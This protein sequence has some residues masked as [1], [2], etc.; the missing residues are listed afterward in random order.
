MSDDY[1]LSHSRLVTRDLDEARSYIAGAWERHTSELRHGRTILMDWRQADFG[2]SSLSFIDSDGPIRA[3]CVPVSRF[4]TFSMHESGAVDH[5]IDGQPITSSPER[6]VLYAPGQTLLMDTHRVR[7]LR[8]SL[9]QD[10]VQSAFARRLDGGVPDSNKWAAGFATKAPAV[11]TLRSL[12]QWLAREF[13]RPMTP[14][15]QNRACA[16]RFERVLLSLLLD[17]LVPQ[18]VASARR[19]EDLDAAQL[20]RVEEWLDSHCADAITVDD[21]AVIAGV[22]V[23]ALRRGFQR[24]RGC[25]PSEAIQRRRLDHVR[26]ALRG[27]G[28]EVN[29]TRAAMDAGFFHLGRFAMR[30]SQV[31]GEKPSDTLAR[32]RRRPRDPR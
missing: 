2:N 16:L 29:V 18:D 1:L 8:V 27:G 10:L 6:A 7:R 24:L 21:L 9:G 19:S 4:Y 22:S 13:D 11:A 17:V 25:T 31:F 23:R 5:V 12:C 15:L 32:H 30:Y 26:H 3:L 28:P 14:L 20:R